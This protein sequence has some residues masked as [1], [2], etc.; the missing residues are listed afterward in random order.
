MIRFKTEFTNENGQK[1]M[2]EIKF[3]A[4]MCEL[5]IMRDDNPSIDQLLTPLEAKILGRLMNPLNVEPGY[6]GTLD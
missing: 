3:H 4:G 5:S 2:F 1:V 6:V